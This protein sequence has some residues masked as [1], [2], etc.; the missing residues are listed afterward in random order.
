M[1]LT[2]NSICPLG[3]KARDVSSVSMCN[4][5]AARTPDTQRYVFPSLKPDVAPPV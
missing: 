4:F 1:A 2:Q 3:R 5:A